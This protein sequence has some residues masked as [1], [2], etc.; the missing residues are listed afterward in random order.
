MDT[1]MKARLDATMAA[2]TVLVDT[3]KGGE[4]Y[5]QMIGADNPAGNAKVQAAIDALVAQT[6]TLEKAVAALALTDI[7]FEGSASLDDPSKVK[8]K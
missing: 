3:A 5:D 6:R 2:M 8:K 4:A 7:K 1:E